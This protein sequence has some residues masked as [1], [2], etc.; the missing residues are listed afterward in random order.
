M[1]VSAFPLGDL[2]SVLDHLSTAD[3]D[4]ALVPCRITCIRLGRDQVG[5]VA[6][7]VSA[8]LGE[9][10]ER[11]R[12]VLVVDA[13]PIRRQGQDL[14][15][16]VEAQ[17]RQRFDVHREVLADEHP[18]LHADEHAIDAASRAA[19]GAD[20]VVTIG[21]GTIT[22]IG[23][24]ASIAAGDIPLVVVQTAAS[25]DG[26]T[27]NV[28]VILRSGVKRTVDSRWPDVVVA[29]VETISEAP[30]SM[31]RAGFG[32]VTS[33]FTAPADWKLAAVLQVDTS[34]H[35]APTELL[36]A[37]GADID[38]WSPGVAAAD[39][40][41]V[42]RLTWA[43]AV[44][45]IA[46]G[47][48]G[49]TAV[50]SGVEHLVSH[51]LDLHH[52]E[53]GLPLGFHGAQ[54]GA[55][56]VVAAGAWELLFERLANGPVT[57]WLPDVGEARAR[58]EGA[59]GHLGDRI[60]DEC[61]RDYSRKLAVWSGRRAE[62]EAAL[63]SWSEH[64]PGLRRLV[65]PSADIARQLRAA[66]AAARFVD[67]EPSVEDDLARWAVANC[68]LMRNRTTVVDLLTFLGSWEPD[69]VERVLTAADSAAA[70]P[71]RQSAVPSV[72]GA[73]R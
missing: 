26:F 59:F 72:A 60:V 56:A 47:V 20:A 54:V 9:R 50:L 41:A 25:V 70:G 10:A 14:K 17:L 46:T 35:R 12:V 2:S 29:D 30:A 73:G 61:W 48:S 4:G 38:A 55:A 57:L 19:A 66:G 62:I 32:E 3:P 5:R 23:K 16:L 58:V 21:G 33:M 67:L 45:G 28:S 24:L 18:V 22:D 13:T 64:A 53:R 31:N 37:V 49:S 71:D 51:M 27:D 65:R 8:L 36:A 43:L 7:E 40:D 44:R 6:D 1:T 52:S 34:F 11:P 69:N 63:A 68:A 15:D 42:E 39:V